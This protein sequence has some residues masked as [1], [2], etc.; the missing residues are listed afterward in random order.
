MASKQKVVAALSLLNAATVWGLIWYPYRVLA[1]AGIS[2]QM[3]TFL[4]YAFAV[5]FGLFVAGP[6]WREL[7]QAGWWGVAL[8]LA[9]GWTNL[10][11]V[12]A[13]LGGQV[14]RVLLLFYLA[15]L[16]TVLLSRLMLGERLDRYG[17]AIIGL[18]LGGAFVML[19]QPQQGLPLP[20][21][22]AEW[23]GLSA[24]MGFAL[25]NVL[26][27]RVQ[28]LTINFK[29]M[30]VLLGAALL[31]ALALGGH[32]VVQMQAIALPDWGLMLLVALVLCTTGFSMQ[33]GLA[34]TPANQA[35]ILLMFELVVAAVSS[36][37]LAHE[38][39]GAREIFGAAL[40]VTASL[41][42][43]KLYQGDEELQPATQEDVK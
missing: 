35:I 32:P 33:Y 29:A 5:G 13:V 34:V 37:F 10:G 42:S 20:Q 18:S 15:P 12:L 2:G 36:Y 16:W 38:T 28:Q 19:W 30:A 9:S 6:V 17:Y 22:F 43:G 23:M 8:A 1:Q 31:T 26:S 11:Y 14:M 39:M 21:N 3:S 7:R 24:G 40:I 25:T 27:R 4:T 41:F